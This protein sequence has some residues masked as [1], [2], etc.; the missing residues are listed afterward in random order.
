MSDYIHTHPYELCWWGGSVRAGKTVQ[1]LSDQT[2]CPLDEVEKNL[3]YAV[4]VYR[5]T[6]PGMEMS[7]EKKA[8][9]LNDATGAFPY[10]R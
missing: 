4:D 5:I 8:L 3:R 7:R 2:K 9:R 10:N 1:K 6:R